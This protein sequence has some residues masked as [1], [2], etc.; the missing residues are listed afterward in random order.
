[1]VVCTAGR[2]GPHKRRHV[3]RVQLAREGD[4][5]VILWD[6]REGPAPIASYREGG[7]QTL[8]FTCRSCGRSW[9]RD[10]D[11]IVET[12]IALGEMQGIWPGGNTPIEI[13][14]ARIERA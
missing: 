7:G 2:R 3:R 13:D 1:V 10:H 5:L 6:L 9:E 11:R 14:V 12:V 8:V 4:Q